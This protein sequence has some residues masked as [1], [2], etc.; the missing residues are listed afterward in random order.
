MNDNLEMNVTCQCGCGILKFD[1]LDWDDKNN[2]CMNIAFYSLSFYEKQ[3]GIFNIMWNRIKNAAKMLLGKEF[4]L[5][6]VIVSKE[7]IDQLKE[8]YE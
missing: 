8:F 1:K 5:Y 3:A 2:A 6:E 7:Q 4:L